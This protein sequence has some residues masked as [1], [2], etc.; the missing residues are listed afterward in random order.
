[1]TTISQAAKAKAEELISAHRTTHGPGMNAARAAL[2][3]VL[4]R[5]G[6]A[7]DLADAIAAEH[8][9]A[10]GQSLLADFKLAKDQPAPAETD[11]RPY[12][13]APGC[14]TVYCRDC[15]PVLAD[16]INIGAKGSTRCRRHAEEA[17]KAAMRQRPEFA[18]SAPGG[19]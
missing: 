15:P 4:Q 9:Y 6:D 1:M 12:G 5:I 3:E 16:L 13:W 8:G 2:E 7:A 17:R 11:L 18:T 19:A 10:H 14:Y